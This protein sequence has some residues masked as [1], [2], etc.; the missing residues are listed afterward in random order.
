VAE[1][2]AGATPLPLEAEVQTELEKIQARAL[3]ASETAG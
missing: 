2:L 1:L 3:R